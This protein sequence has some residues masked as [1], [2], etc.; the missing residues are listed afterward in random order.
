M[1]SG[2]VAGQR[3]SGSQAG[4]ARCASLA[5][6]GD[7]GKARE[8]D[9]SL[10]RTP[11]LFMLEKEATRKFLQDSHSRLAKALMAGDFGGGQTG[12]MCLGR[13]VSCTER[14]LLL[15]FRPAHRATDRHYLPQREIFGLHTN[16]IQ[17]RPR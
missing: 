12:D 3:E 7:E 2:N 10:A 16:I 17:H 15:W 13:R 4:A 11:Y 6:I 8:P 9:S 5:A 14:A 1:H